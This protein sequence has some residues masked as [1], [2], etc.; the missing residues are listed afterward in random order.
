MATHPNAIESGSVA[1]SNPYAAPESDV[2]QKLD[3]RVENGSIF[4]GS[5]R[6]SVVSFLVH[7]AL[8]TIIQLSLS[9][10]LN[11]VTNAG[12]GSPDAGIAVFRDNPAIQW[13]PN[14]ILSSV[15]MWIGLCLIVKRLHDRSISGWWLLLLTVIPSVI[16]GALAYAGMAEAAFAPMLLLLAIFVIVL[17]PGKNEPNQFGARRATRGWEKVFLISSLVLFIVVGVSLQFIDL[18]SLSNT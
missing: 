10:M 7:Y 6:L 15:G 1:S 8:F 18:P 13:I 5:G 2:E 17:L 12:S 14:L 3:H 16:A 4:W 9:L 11:F